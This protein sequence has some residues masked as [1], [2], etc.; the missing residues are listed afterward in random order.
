MLKIKVNYPK[1]T[2]VWITKT[3][4]TFWLSE[5]VTKLLESDNVVGIELTKVEGEDDN[6]RL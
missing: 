3:H 2:E 5:L 6:R 1:E 4:N